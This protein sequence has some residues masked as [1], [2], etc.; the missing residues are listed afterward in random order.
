MVYTKSFYKDP[1]AAPDTNFY[2]ILFNRED[3]K[4][5]PDYTLH[6]DA[7]TGRRRTYRQY[8]E[9]VR[10]GATVLRAGVSDGGLGLAGEE[11]GEIVGIMSENSMDYIVLITSLI[12]AAIPFAPI[13]SYSKPFELR[14]ALKLSKV[15]Q[16]FVHARFLPSVLPIA[17]EVGLSTQRIY[18]LGGRINGRQSFADMIDNV[19]HN[20]IPRIPVQ[21]AKKDT[22]A[23]LVFSSGTT[24]L[25]KAVM[26]SHG[27]LITS[28][29]QSI[30]VGIEMKSV[31]TPPPIPTPEGIP[32]SLAF[33][34]FHHS[35]G[36]H[37]FIFKGFLAPT[38]FVFMDQW[39]IDRALEAVS[40]YR[41]TNLLLVPSVVHQLVNHPGTKKAD[42]S[43]VIH[44]MS[45]AAY[46][47]P[48]LSSKMTSLTKRNIPVTEGFGMS[49]CTISAMLKPFPG[50]L[51]GRGK[52]V[53]G[54]SGILL[55]G[56]EARIVREDGSETEYNEAGELWLRGANVAMGYWDNA[57]ATA[58]TFLT[59]GWLRTGDHFRV[60]EDGYFFFA[61]RAKDTLKVS[62]SQV[63]PVEIENV[64]LAHPDKLIMDVSVAGVSGGRT[65]DEKVP[66]AWVVLSPAGKKVGA[67]N[68]V[69]ALVAWH[70]ENLSK[71]KWLRGGIEIVPEVR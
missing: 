66:R 62:G 22:L 48:E 31:Y 11:H 54:S 58:E 34:P 49:E 23:Y 47:P 39:N 10:D 7:R 33:L 55:P 28:M 3:Q 38:T 35:Y 16:L 29:L 15:T 71:F 26:I 44:V 12:T 56:L 45:G 50:T 6:I 57:Q 14:H 53:E 18:I 40:K 37:A 42:L 1:P 27:N 43:S 24:G 60:T 13:P 20:N 41:I 59:D 46:L 30:V 51:G 32:I 67:A 69:K 61:D 8:L 2:N 70:E 5:W 9:R 68:V 19:R 64:L 63:S 17:K 25:P 65:S 52:L 4:S 36:L 21:P